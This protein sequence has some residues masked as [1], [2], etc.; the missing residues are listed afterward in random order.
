MRPA[1]PVHSGSSLLAASVHRYYVLAGKYEALNLSG[2][3]SFFKK[4]PSLK[5]DGNL[6]VDT[7]TVFKGLSDVLDLV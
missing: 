5:Q 2:Y 4:S 1:A 6:D 7:R 3:I